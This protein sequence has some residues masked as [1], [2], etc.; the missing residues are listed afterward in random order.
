MYTG[1]HKG[2]RSPAG[3]PHRLPTAR[4]EGPMQEAAGGTTGP[5]ADGSGV[6]GAAKVLSCRRRSATDGACH[7]V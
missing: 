5:A 3:R 7:Q 1:T 6:G 4:Q 2:P